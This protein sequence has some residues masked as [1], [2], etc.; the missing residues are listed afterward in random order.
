MI[1]YEFPLLLKNSR[2]KNVLLFWR[3][4]TSERERDRQTDRQYSWRI[5]RFKAHELCIWYICVVSFAVVCVG[6][7]D[8]DLVL[9]FSFK[10]YKTKD[11]ILNNTGCLQLI[12]SLFK[13]Y[14]EYCCDDNVISLNDSGCI[15]PEPP[16]KSFFIKKMSAPTLNILIYSMSNRSSLENYLWRKCQICSNLQIHWYWKWE[17]HCII[18]PLELSCT[19][20]NWMVMLENVSL[21]RI[22]PDVLSY[23]SI[24][25]FV[26]QF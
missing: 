25:L 24:I 16:K 7:G 14:C 15:T 9:I 11:S 6:Q 20:L 12:F 21:N 13:L 2:L 8:G 26:C 5:H 23:I 22:V 3:K 17:T 1:R 4:I 18:F 10:D 19:T